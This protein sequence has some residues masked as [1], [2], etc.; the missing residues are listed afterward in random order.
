MFSIRGSLLVIFAL[1]GGLAVTLEAYAST[2]AERDCPEA[3]ARV[4]LVLRSEIDPLIESHAKGRLVP[5]RVKA[6]SLAAIAKASD[7]AAYCAI[8]SSH[9]K[10]G[11]PLRESLL[12]EASHRLNLIRSNLDGLRTPSCDRGCV[13]GLM[14]MVKSERERLMKTLGL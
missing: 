11:I 9:A 14:G 1:G 12:Y 13:D 10:P 7:L 4:I 3:K 8:G 6:Q 2:P 5:A